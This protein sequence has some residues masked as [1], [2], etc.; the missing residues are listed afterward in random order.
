M[1]DRLTAAYFA[2]RCPEPLPR[3]PVP[4]MAYVPFQ[5]YSAVYQPEVGLERGT[6]FPE[7]DKPFIGKRGNCR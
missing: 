7:L 1:A 6:I 5:Q 2:R 3:N 4:V